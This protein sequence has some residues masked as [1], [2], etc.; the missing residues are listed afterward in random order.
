MLENQIRNFVMNLR[1]L[2]D[3]MDLLNPVLED[4]P[5]KVFEKTQPESVIPFLI[6]TRKMSCD[7]LV[8]DFDE[9]AFRK[10]FDG[11][12]EVDIK[13]ANGTKEL[14]GIQVSGKHA[15]SSNEFLSKLGG[16]LK[17]INLLQDSSLIILMNAV[18]WFFSEILHAY[19]SAHP[20]IVETDEKSLSLRDL[21][22]FGSIEEARDYLIERKVETI[23]RGSV[24]DWVDFLK[25][26]AKLKMSYLKPTIDKM[27]EVQKRR[28]L[29]IHNNGTVN[30]I[31]LSNVPAELT[32]NLKV[33]DKITGDSEYLDSSLEM[34][35]LNCILV[36]AELWKKLSVVDANRPRVLSHLAYEN[37]EEQH[38]KI[39]EGLSYFSMNDSKVPEVYTKLAKLNY[40]LSIKR[41]GRWS[42]IAEDA[43]NEDFSA[44][45][46]RYRLGWLAL[47]EDNDK[48]FE[49]VPEVIK[50]GDITLRELK[51]FPIFVEIRKDS[52]FATATK[53]K[54]TLKKKTPKKK[55]PKKKKTAIKKTPQQSK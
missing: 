35:E 25:K 50:V 18:E 54:N 38:W 34:F 39:T 31:Y 24:L 48:F 55:T 33:G 3:F 23:L 15:V 8:G 28:N 13:E 19:F 32:V 27:L 53:K 16:A 14:V 36:A 43:K 9:A 46:R 42:E 40:W 45:S 49:L 47:C 37:L 6:A 41:Q 4:G 11:K 10:V 17:R 12:I 7:S 20:E 30:R 26:N 5:R 44:V 29:I 52:R 21:G 2:R 22:R 1:S 51:K